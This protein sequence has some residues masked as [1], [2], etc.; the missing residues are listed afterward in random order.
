MDN[1]NIINNDI[2]NELIINQRKNITNNMRLSYNDMKRISKY[3]SKSLFINSDECSIWNGY[4][5]SIK[6][7]KHNYINFFFNK[8]KYSLQ[9]LLYI[10]YVDN[11]E[12]NE[13]LKFSCLNKGICCN[14][15][16]FYK[17]NDLKITNNNNNIKK[18][19]TNDNILINE[20]KICDNIIVNFN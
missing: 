19:N 13:Y 2:I 16:H 8:K 15:K 18:L 5:L 11:L 9:R 20:K 4:I 17:I 12:N 6:N 7:Y 10:N 3:L 1:I 14:I